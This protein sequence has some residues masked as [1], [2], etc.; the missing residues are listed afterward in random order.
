MQSKIDVPLEGSV[1]VD[2]TIKLFK[3]PP[4]G[5]SLA[6]R[7]FYFTMPVVYRPASAWSSA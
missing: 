7:S 5:G 3:L 6:R 2:A 4:P 1:S